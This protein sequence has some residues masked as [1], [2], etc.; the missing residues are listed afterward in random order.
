[1]N[2]VARVRAFARA[3]AR[4]QRTWSDRYITLLA[5]GLLVV[6]AA[7]VIERAVST[8]PSD[9]DPARAGAGLALVGLSLAVLLV[10]ARA[11][12]P[13]GVS[14]ADAAWLVLSPL[15]RRHVLTRTLLVLAGV[16][17]VV[18]AL[19]GVVL[20]SALGA[21]DAL[22]L[23]LLASVAVG[24]SWTLGA[25]SATVLAQ[26]SQIWGDRLVALLA[27]LVVAAAVALA[28]MGLGPGHRALVAVASAPAA[29][30]T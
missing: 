7:P 15:P 16:C 30:W 23:R 11:L 13:V 27:A 25:M 2:E 21:S 19:L 9:V 24:V 3:G 10:L 5:L 17:A 18:G 14:A 20:L 28:V 6:L 29:T 12:G 1:M 8:V 26:T 22:T 4:R